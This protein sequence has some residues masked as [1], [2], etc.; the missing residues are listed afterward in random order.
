MNI[1]NGK[2]LKQIV[3]EINLYGHQLIF[4]YIDDTTILKDK[5]TQQLISNMYDSMML[6]QQYNT[7]ISKEVL[8]ELSHYPIIFIG[9]WTDNEK[10]EY[11]EV[12]NNEYINS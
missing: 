2:N 5:D 10:N 3:N 12:F 4:Y 7:N 9:D 11:Q 6:P 1:K 8:K